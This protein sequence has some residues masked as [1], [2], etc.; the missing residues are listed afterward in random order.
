MEPGEAELIPDVVVQEVGEVQRA[1]AELAVLTTR[2]RDWPAHE[3]LL[4][5]M[6]EAPEAHLRWSLE[7]H[8][9]LAKRLHSQHGMTSTLSADALARQHVS[10]LDAFSDLNGWWF[11][12]AV[13][14]PIEGVNVTP[15]IE[16]MQG[17]I[18]TA[19]RWRGGVSFGSDLADFRAGAPLREEWWVRNWHT[20]IAFPR[21]REQERLFYRF[22]V[23]GRAG[24]Y[25]SNAQR[26]GHLMTFVTFGTTPDVRQPITNWTTVGWPV[27]IA[28]PYTGGFPSFGNVVPISGN[29]LVQAGQ[30]PA[31][32][33][34]VGVIVGLAGGSLWLNPLLSNFETLMIERAPGSAAIR[35]HATRHG[36]IEYRHDPQWW[37]DAVGRIGLERDTPELS[38]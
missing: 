21:V 38:N 16:G 30:T 24:W 11:P 33:L 4:A 36:K 28:L 18:T 35:D 37:L 17:E 26:G 3:R 6:G 5:G 13:P 29:M 10:I 2:L 14:V 12:R 20:T 34:I 9:E 22:E 23:V 32:G 15:G 7:R 8:A 27:D 31:I 25:P 1:Q 19:S